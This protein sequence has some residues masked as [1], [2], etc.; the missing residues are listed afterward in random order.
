MSPPSGAPRKDAAALLS[1][2]PGP[3]PIPAEPLVGRPEVDLLTG[4]E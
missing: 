4:R 3:Y 2:T 1:S